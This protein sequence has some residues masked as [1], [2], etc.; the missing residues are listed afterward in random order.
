LSRRLPAAEEGTSLDKLADEARRW[1]PNASLIKASAKEL[2]GL[3]LPVIAHGWA[4][5]QKGNTGHYVVVV[6]VTQK[7]VTYVDAGRGCTEKVPRRGFDAFWSGYALAPEDPPGKLTRR[8]AVAFAVLAALCGSVGVWRGSWRKRRRAATALLISFALLCGCGH[9]SASES[10][11]PDRAGTPK[12][13]NPLVCFEKEKDLGI[14]APG[15]PA[16][17]VFALYNAK[18][19]PLELAL[20]APSCGCVSAKL[21]KERLEPRET[22]ELRLVLSDAG[23]GAGRRSGSVAV[24]VVG[25]RQPSVTCT[26]I[27][28]LEGI[29]TDRYSLRLPPNLAGFSPAPISG[30][31]VMGPARREDEARILAVLLKDNG[32]RFLQL[33][34]PV[35]GKAENMGSYLRRRFEIP[36]TLGPGKRPDSREYDARITYQIAGRTADQRVPLFVFPEVTVPPTAAAR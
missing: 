13:A 14:F 7:A 31:L 20:G 18:D 33:G 36:V 3:P 12:G 24:G 1:T 4:S 26:A 2:D 19:E 27:G 28:I 10:S 17:A 16:Q 35:I 15:E 21:S 5:G 30:E 22:A 32:E 34:A 25:L 23:G 9:P 11:S 6:R 8:L 29:Q